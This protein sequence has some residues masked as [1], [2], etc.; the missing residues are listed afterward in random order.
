MVGVH[1]LKHLLH[2]LGSVLSDVSQCFAMYVMAQTFL[3]MSQFLTRLKLHGENVPKTASLRHCEK[4][5][6][7]WGT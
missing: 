6:L 5:V 2:P 4:I 1:S 7:L 3:Y